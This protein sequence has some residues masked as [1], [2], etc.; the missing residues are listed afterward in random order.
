[1]KILD[2]TVQNVRGLPYIQ[3]HPVGRSA[4]IWG[5]N[6]SG[7]SG[8]V[9]AIDFLLTGR[10]T[11]L[12]GEGT[13]GITLA[14]HGPHIDHD[15]DSA[16]VT[17]TIELAGFAEP[18]VIKRCIATPYELEC[19]DEAQV[20]LADIRA[21]VWRGGSILTRR[22]ILRYI[23]AEAGTRA[24]EIQELLNLR[25]VES[26]RNSLYR[27]R[28]EL[29][30]DQ[31]GA[32]NAIATAKADVSVTLGVDEYSDNQV[33]EM[34][35]RSRALLGG[36][37][38]E[39]YHSGN[40]KE[41]LD[42]PMSVKSL[43]TPFNRTLFQQTIDNVR[44]ETAEEYSKRVS[45]ADRD[46]REH[47]T[48]IKAQKML[49]DELE[50]L[51]LTKL[52]IKFVNEQSTACPVCGAIWSQGYLEGHLKGKLHAA[53][54]AELEYQQI[55][56]LAELVTMPI[57]SLRANVQSLAD[58]ATM[59]A[60]GQRLSEDTEALHSWSAA[61]NDLL[62]ALESPVDK[63]PGSDIPQE[64]VGSFLAPPQIHGGCRRP[65]KPKLQNQVLSRPHGILLPA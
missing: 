62:Q 53:R 7:K 18:I 32:R 26:I 58:T 37:P 5:P 28:T 30:R 24:D 39:A 49:L 13:A 65:Q 10:I 12:V 22:D 21:V 55:K 46:L 57:R 8:V 35:N 47:L 54:Q 14:K 11:R 19:P 64:M 51:D 59:S 52:A 50:Q 29:R 9:D 25:D 44:G 4:V 33:I 60:F 1:M 15:A 36:E 6:G 45:D 41:T 34:V 38:I 48:K 27:A 23:A 56:E 31:Q 61:L 3:L 17:A 2:L 63:Y 20:A 43:Q 42:P 40:L 16:V